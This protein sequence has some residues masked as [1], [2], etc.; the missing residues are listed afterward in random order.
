MEKKIIFWCKQGI[1]DENTANLLLDDIKQDSAKRRKIQLNI[2]IYTISVILIGLG[3]ITFVSANYWII[4]LLNRTKILKIILLLGVTLSTFWGGFELAYVRKNFPRLGNALIFL[5]TLLIGG[6]YALIGQVYHTNAN[7]SS[8][9]FIW[10]ISIL[11]VAYLFKSKAVNIISIVLLILGIVFYYMELA[12]DKSLIWTIFI[13]ILCG[14]ILYTVGNI[15]IVLKKYND[16]SLMYKVVGMLPI[17]ITLLILTCISESSYHITSPY[18]I[19]PIVVLILLNFLNII[20]NKSNDFLLKIETIF[21]VAM[22]CLLLLLLILPSVNVGLT[23]F[24]ANLFIITM[25]VFGFYYGY[26]FENEKI[27]SA[28]NKILMLYLLV[29]YFRWGW[30]F[31]DKT[32]FFLLGGFGLLTVGILLE[33]NKIKLYKRED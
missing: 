14:M 7:S 15:P 6:T 24:C 11:P 4:E 9:M 12:I 18:Y 10:L 22:L 25:L 28:T 20:I 3:V 23:I 30:S 16:F 8:L 32:L 29:S 33:K 2:L 31:M 27:I 17:F 5:S 1:I 26:K 19:L 21:S 13:P